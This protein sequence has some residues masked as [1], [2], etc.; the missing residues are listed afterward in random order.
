MT[1]LQ[2]IR[3]TLITIGVP[4]QLAPYEGDEESTYIVYKTTEEYGDDFGDD[5]AGLD[6]TECEVS[7]CCPLGENPSELSRELKRR[8]ASKECFTYPRMI[9]DF[10]PEQKRTIW[11]YTFQY[12]GT[13][14]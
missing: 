5:D 14:I 11:T 7:L 9:S 12:D 4:V 13:G 1:A 6:V 3:E 8:I 10:D 2:A